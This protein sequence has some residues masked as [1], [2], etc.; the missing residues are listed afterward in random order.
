M[1]WATITWSM[2]AGGSLTLA[3]IHWVLW[4]RQRDNWA[5]FSFTVAAVA[6]AVLAMQELALMHAQNPAEYGETLRWM[7]VSVAALTIAIVWFIWFH[8]GTGRLWLAWLVIGLRLMSVTVNFI[9]DPNTT[10]QEIHGLR[11]VRFLGESL[12]APV[13]EMSPWRSIVYLMTIFLLAYVTDACYVAWKRGRRRSALILGISILG[14]TALSAVFSDLMVRG[15]LPGPLMAVAFLI[16]VFAM[17]AELSTDLLRSNRL[18]LEL[19]ESEERMRLAARAADLGFWEWDVVQDK[20]WVSD[21]PS[22]LT[23]KTAPGQ[24]GLDPYLERI[25]PDDRERLRQAVDQS[26]QRNQ[27]FRSEFRIT[28][29][30]GVERWV[31]A[32]G[33]L[34]QDERSKTPRLRGVSMNI[35]ARK[36]AEVELHRKRNELA[37]AQRAAALGQLS[38]AL[39]H[40]LNQPL[41]AI[42]RNAEAGELFLQREPP[43]LAEVRDILRD[44]KADNQR[45]A[46]VIDRLRS[47]L[48]YGEIQLETV[49]LQPLVQQVV[50]LLGV[51]L[52]THQVNLRTTVPQDLPD[53]R[54]DRIH[55][56]QV[57]LNLLLNSME[58]LDSMPASSRHIEVGAVR[59]DGGFIE[60]TVRDTGPGIDQDMLP[61]L[62]EP[63]LTSKA[64]GTGLGLAISRT[65][66]EAHGGRI[67]AT[68]N[69]GGGACIRIE[70]PV[71]RRD[72]AT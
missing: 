15:V 37:L 44:I 36:E 48:R 25:H 21:E 7:Q 70:L 32:V 20:V 29:A 60:L 24:G 56:Q 72:G 45:A 33:Q 6:A 46:A 22:R 12:S 19:Q 50:A 9:V 2:I 59:R 4:T 58:A 18:A 55:L 13:G 52:Q 38:S 5:N 27:E 53:V 1:S 68:N 14:A 54:G 39:T 35:G 69:P 17:A 41:G 8:L 16:I 31:H 40:E 62:F 63:F 11:E 34:V 67:D 66:I 30:D 61:V 57:L 28:G 71:A 23:G 49:A 42:L 10:F 65:I 64:K 26:V 3:G 43:D 51:E 47:L